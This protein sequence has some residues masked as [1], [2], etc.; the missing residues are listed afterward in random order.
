MVTILILNKSDDVKVLRYAT[1]NPHEAARLFSEDWLNGKIRFEIEIVN[2]RKTS[3]PG[4]RPKM[5]EQFI[6]GEN[7]RL[8]YTLK[9]TAKLLGVSYATVHRLLQRRLIASS[10]ALRT[11]LIPRS[12][13]ERFLKE[14]SC[15]G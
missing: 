6:E 13:I 15:E 12:E 2:G 3:E 9:E 1:D 11:K 7:N 4:L 14:T 5:S 8:A 10:H